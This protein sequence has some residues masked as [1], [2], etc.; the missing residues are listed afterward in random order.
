VL[1]L[2]R[3]RDDK[4]SDPTV[5]VVVCTATHERSPLL[6]SCIDSLLAGQRKPDELILVVDSNPSLC[7]ELAAVLPP[8]VRLL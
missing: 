4:A 1:T 8:E 7:A 6:R 5:A 2:P 3:S